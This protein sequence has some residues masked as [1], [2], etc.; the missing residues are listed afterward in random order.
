MDEKNALS[1]ILSS[2]LESV[3][4]NRASDIAIL[5]RNY[6]DEKKAL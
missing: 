4:G 1:F 5:L 3:A 6:M 2:G